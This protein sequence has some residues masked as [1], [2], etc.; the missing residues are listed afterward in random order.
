M[1]VEGLGPF[2]V[3]ATLV[4]CWARMELAD[5][6]IGRTTPAVAATCENATPD[7]ATAK[8]A[9]KVTDRPQRRAENEIL[10]IT[11]SDV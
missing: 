6:A 4:V 8:R 3:S 7:M 11:K 1:V 9:K 2:T 5:R 10:S